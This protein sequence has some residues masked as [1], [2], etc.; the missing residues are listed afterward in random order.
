MT[1]VA[2]TAVKPAAPAH[3][4]QGIMAPTTRQY[5]AAI[6]S[7]INAADK[8]NKLHAL[9][10]APAGWDKVKPFDV[11]GRTVDFSR[12]AYVIKNEIYLQ[13]GTVMGP[14]FWFKVGPAP[15]F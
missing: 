5:H 9:K 6:K 12:K 10:K 7:I 8:A 4:A 13:T 3:V 1:T 11:S 15:M 2:R 14:K